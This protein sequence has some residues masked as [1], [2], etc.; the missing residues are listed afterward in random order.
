MAAHNSNHE[1]QQL[2]D[3]EIA[4]LTARMQ[5][6][7]RM[8]KARRNELAPVSKLPDEVLQHIFLIFRDS[9]DLD[10]KNWQQGTQICQYWRH[11]AVELP[12]L[13]TLLYDPRMLLFH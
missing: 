6:A 8:L 2:L 10:P 12:L 5:Q 7:I 1:A 3:E 4:D 11:V 9:T 13:W